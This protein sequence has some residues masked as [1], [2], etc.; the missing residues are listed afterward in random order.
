M[1]PRSVIPFS[2]V[3][4]FLVGRTAERTS[5]PLSTANTTNPKI[6]LVSFLSNLPH[7]SYTFI[8]GRIDINENLYWCW[9]WRTDADAET[10]ILWPPDVKNWFLGKDPD[11]GKDWRW[12]EK[13]TTEDEMV[14]WHHRL[15]I[16]HLLPCI[17]GHEFEQALGDGDG[18]GSL[19]CCS[20]WSCKESGMTEWLNY[21]ELIK[22]K[23]GQRNSITIEKEIKRCIGYNVLVGQSLLLERSW[24]FIWNH[25]WI[26]FKSHSGVHCMNNKA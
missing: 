24:R 7:F 1:G 23:Q 15:I 6:T 13:G 9:S 18:Q 19:A 5:K 16:T 11:A 3:Q 8:S 4:C 10:P 22:H 26:D 17:H 25:V 14:G 12:E 21:T 20:P 2:L